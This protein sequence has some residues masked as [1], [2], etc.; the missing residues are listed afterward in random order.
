MNSKIQHWYKKMQTRKYKN[1]MMVEIQNALYVG[2]NI[3]EKIA[4][5]SDY[6]KPKE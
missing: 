1:Q 3:L 4:D 2:K 6:V 5:S